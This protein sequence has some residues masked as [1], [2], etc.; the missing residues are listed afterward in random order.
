MVHAGKEA[1]WEGQPHKTENEF[2][3]DCL[4]M[5]HSDDLG[6]SKMAVLSVLTIKR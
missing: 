2:S 3:D 5:I 1:Q 4:A 6:K